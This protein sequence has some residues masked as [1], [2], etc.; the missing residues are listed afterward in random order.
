MLSL[1]VPELL[2]QFRGCLLGLACGDALGAPLQYMSAEEIAAK[3]GRVREMIGGGELGLA[4]GA[5]TGNTALMLCLVESYCDN[6][7]FDPQ[8]ISDRFLAWYRTGPIGI[9]AQTREAC[10]NLLYGYQF[11][12]AG[13][14]AWE[15]MPE[16]IRQSNGSLARSAPAG[17]MR[18]HD[19]VHLIGESRVVSGITHFDERCKMACA[20]LNL[21]LSH[22]MLVGVDGLLDELLEFIE[23]RNTVVAYALRAIPGMGPADL[24]TGD[25]VLSTLQAALWTAM[26]CDEFEEGLV[27]LARRGNDACSVCAVAGALLGARFGAPEIPERWLGALQHRGRVDAGAR[28]LC[29]LAQAE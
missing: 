5:A 12:R 2:D 13:R 17:L 21:A 24:R 18:Y 6:A 26:Y 25:H 27:M 16:D 10:E 11:E 9:D 14:D 23:P 15:A 1:R 20:C 3:H 7:G 8:D 19:H 22:L 29:A 4:P 28:K